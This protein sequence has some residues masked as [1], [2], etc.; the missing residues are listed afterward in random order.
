MHAS[1]RR[2][3]PL[4]LAGLAF[5]V[6]AA[7][8][9]LAERGSITASFPCVGDGEYVA[10]NDEL[11]HWVGKFTCATYTDSGSGPM[12]RAGW[13]CSGSIDVVKGKIT[14]GG[15]YCK[16]THLDGDVIQVRWDM[17]PGGTFARFD[18]RG[19]YLSGT[20]KYAGIQGS[21]NAEWHMVPDTAV[22]LGTMINS[23]YQIP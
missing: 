6:L 14:V 22:F 17:K 1:A 12:H 18:T 21:Y 23:S 8:T 19:Q 9:A 11:G 5:L 4:F 13:A 16:V 7:A 10:M 20:G 15:G 3:A 2:Y